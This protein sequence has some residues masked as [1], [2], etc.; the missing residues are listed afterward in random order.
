M[1]SLLLASNPGRL[2]YGLVSIACVINH[3]RGPYILSKMYMKLYT[4]FIA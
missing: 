3:R 4:S 1:S 2:K